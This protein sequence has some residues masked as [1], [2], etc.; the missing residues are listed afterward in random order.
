MAWL[1]L[2][3]SDSNRVLDDEEWSKLVHRSSPANQVYLAE[4]E[5]NIRHG[6]CQRLTK[7]NGITSNGQTKSN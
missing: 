6:L 4:A 5:R 2:T 7:L 1:D 3:S